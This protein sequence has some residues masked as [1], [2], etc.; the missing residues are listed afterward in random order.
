MKQGQAAAEATAAPGYE[1]D[2]PIGHEVG[3]QLEDFTLECYDGTGFHLADMRGRIV[4]INLWATYCTPCIQELPW[5]SE[6][7]AAHPDDVAVIAVHSSL[8]TM[9][10][11][12]FLADKSFAMPF[13][14]DTDDAVKN[15]VGGTGT[16]P[17]T[18]VLNRKGEVVYNQVGSITPE[19]LSA[20]YDEANG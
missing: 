8:V 1:S 5:F 16:L 11:A 2:A 20:L 10:P 18:I 17:Q 19:V 14:T 9:D 3:Q 4:F 7:C 15:I 12:E 6:L 13:A